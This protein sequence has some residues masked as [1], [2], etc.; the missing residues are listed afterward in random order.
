M[1]S[2]HENCGLG[3]GAGGR[4]I[5]L[6]SMKNSDKPPF[7]SLLYGAGVVAVVLISFGYFAHSEAANRTTP[8]S[9]TPVSEL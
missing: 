9:D 7:H 8:F 1:R 4:M 5:S 2:L 3:D 6:A